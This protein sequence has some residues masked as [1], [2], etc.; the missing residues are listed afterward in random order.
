MSLFNTQSKIG[1]IGEQKFLSYMESK[2]FVVVDVSKHKW[3]GI[4]N[5]VDFILSKDN[6]VSTWEVK[7]DTKM[8]ITENIFVEKYSNLD[9]EEEGWFTKTK[10]DYICYVDAENSKGYI[11]EIRALKDFIKAYP[12]CRQANCVDWFYYGNKSTKIIRRGYLV[13]IDAFKSFCKREYKNTM[14]L[15]KTL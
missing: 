11:F 8:H 7:T 4:D 13:N 9:K 5:C 6:K 14:L 1:D 3:I 12:M 2:G 15:E 10:A